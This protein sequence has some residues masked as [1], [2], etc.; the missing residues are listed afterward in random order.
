[1]TTAMTE[2]MFFLIYSSVFI[3][4][5]RA[6]CESLINSGGKVSSG[7]KSTYPLDD[8]YFRSLKNSSSVKSKMP[9]ASYLVR[10]R[11]ILSSWGRCVCRYSRIFFDDLSIRRIISRGAG[12]PAPAR[13]GAE[14]QGGG[15]GVSLS[16]EANP[17][18]SAESAAAVVAPLPQGDIPAPAKEETA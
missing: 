7:I 8:R 12:E 18:R 17:D 10:P 4:G 9:S 6:V 1:M 5:F 3:F 16:G 11:R 13:P 14:V 2:R 15:N